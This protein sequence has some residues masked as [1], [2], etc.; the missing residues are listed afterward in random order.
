MK[1]LKS[2]GFLPGSVVV[3]S[4]YELQVFQ[5]I[6]ITELNN[7]YGN[8]EYLAQEL[9]DVNPLTWAS[10]KRLSIS[11]SYKKNYSVLQG[12]LESLVNNASLIL[13]G[14]QPI[15]QGVS[16]SE[17]ENTGLLDFRGKETLELIKQ[18][19]E[20]KRQTLAEQ[21]KV[22]KFL[23]QQQDNRL[24]RLRS[25]MSFEVE[26][27]QKYIKKV[28]KAIVTLELYLGIEETIKQLVEGLPADQDLP[29]SLRQ[30]VLYMDEE[31]ALDL[32][33]EDTLEFD[34][35]TISWFDQWLLADKT[36]LDKLLPEKKGMVALKPR[37]Y[38]KDYGEA[39][40][41][42]G[43]FVN[44]QKNIANTTHTYFLI[45]NGENVYRVWTDNLS[46]GR[47]MFP[48]REKLQELFQQYQDARFDRDK[49]QVDTVLY[50]YR[51][52]T[53]FTQGLIDRTQVF[54]LMAGRLN[55]FNLTEDSAKLV[56]FIYDGELLLADGRLS[57]ND[58]KNQINEKLEEGSRVL[59]LRP[60]KTYGES[61][62]WLLRERILTKTYL[63]E[64]TLKSYDLPD[65]GVYTLVKKSGIFSKKDQ[66]VLVILYSPT[67]TVV[68]KT[69][70]SYEDEAERK[71]RVSYLIKPYQDDLINYDQL[72]LAD[73]EYYLHD[74]A[75]R[76]NYV[77]FLPLLKRLTFM[78]QKDQAQEKLFMQLVVDEAWRKSALHLSLEAVEKA[79]SW[80]KLKNKWKRAISQ[81]D[82]KALRMILSYLKHDVK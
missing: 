4:S 8:D 15:P 42:W 26:K 38:S 73:I 29:I 16:S 74:R 11:N 39:G 69:W 66:D 51:K 75:Q 34:F 58:W 40:S 17:E 78:L 60:Y 71:Q 48:E 76:Q 32:S 45:R 53:F 10:P 3:Y 14:K 21:E 79:V 6:E 27:L 25:Q 36:R 65:T 22:L 12:D 61:K 77:S 59:F 55:L 43:S 62:V 13:A 19:A 54:G 1:E 33:E 20:Q 7:K 30:S 57:F 47:L 81:D 28:E 82:A 50:N 68:K 56:Q 49:E 64:W 52:V 41:I 31:V 72:D 23:I 35:E 46:V 24:K 2:G 5:I 63:N 70:N 44:S 37:R 67:K 18:E 80:W 9:I